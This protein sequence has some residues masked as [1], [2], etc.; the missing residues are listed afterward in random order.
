MSFNPDKCEVLRVT[1]K[2]KPIIRNYTIHG[3][4]LATVQSA[5]YVGLHIS[6]NLSLNQYIRTVYK[7]LYNISACLRRSISTC[8]NT[9]KAQCYTTLVRPKVEYASI[10]SDPVTEKHYELEMV[11]RR[12]ARFVTG[13]YRTTSSVTKMLK[14]LQLPT[15]QERKRKAKV[16]T[17]YRIVHHLIEIPSQTY[18][19]PMGANLTT[20][21]HDVRFLLPY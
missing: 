21:G 17:L 11:Q 10:K 4:N 2:R 1:N 18:T 15:L 5:K 8:P 7:K 14:D 13:N 12:A 19:V 6:S 16:N 3:K 20:R 9:T